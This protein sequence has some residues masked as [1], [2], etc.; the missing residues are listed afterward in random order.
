MTWFH[1]F[2][3]GYSVVSACV[4]V[5]RWKDKTANQANSR[6][7]SSRQ[8]GVVLLVLVALSGFIAGLFYRVDAPLIL[9]LAA[10]LVAVVSILALHHRQVRTLLY[11]IYDYW[12]SFSGLPHNW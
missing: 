10:V 1:L 2:Q 4:I 5:L 7:L 8:E 6:W 3:T 9:P 12:S 11:T